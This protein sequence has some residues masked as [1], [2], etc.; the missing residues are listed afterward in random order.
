LKRQ[1][2]LA[3]TAR[4]SPAKLTCAGRCAAA[5]FKP[6][7]LPEDEKYR[8]MHFPTICRSTSRGSSIMA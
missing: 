2:W 1:L 4:A 3:L 6:D 7:R 5:E 8:Q